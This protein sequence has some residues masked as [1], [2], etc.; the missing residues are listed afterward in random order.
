MSNK[1]ML[2]KPAGSEDNC[3][4][5]ESILH[6]IH[7][8]QDLLECISD[9][10]YDDLIP[11]TAAEWWDFAP[12]QPIDSAPLQAKILMRYSDG[13]IRLLYCDKAE[14]ENEPHPVEW[15]PL[16]DPKPIK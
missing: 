8:Q 1:P 6:V 14:L 2:Y 12:W 10:G 3:I 16:P 7:D 15:L 11:L 4:T 5:D 13:I 9:Y